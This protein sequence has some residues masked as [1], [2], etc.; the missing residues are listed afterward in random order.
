M[1]IIITKGKNRNTLTCKRAD[2]TQTRTSLGPNTPNHDIAHY[3]VEKTL[4]LKKGFYGKIKSGMSIKELSE[5]NLIK[6]LDSET[7]L[8]E[9]LTRNLQS[10]RSGAI[11][12]EQFIE[13]IHWESQNISNIQVPDI[14][15]TD[16][17]NMKTK[18]YQL[19][20]KWNTIPEDKAL[21]LIF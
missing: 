2:K 18:F 15:L 4:N 20:E 19:C 1:E 3:V 11:K 6:T 8:S 14:T 7:W 12:T 5:K 10:I 9:I 21:K 13:L 16:V 17:H